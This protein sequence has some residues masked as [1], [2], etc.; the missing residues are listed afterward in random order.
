MKSFKG[1]LKEEVAWQQSTSKMIFDFGDKFSIKIP[2]S[3]AILDKIFPDKIKTTVFH[4]TDVTKVEKLI[5]LQKKQKMVSSFF[6]MDTNYLTMGINTGGGVVAELDGN[7]VV[8]AKSDI[9]SMPDK[10]G[11]RWIELGTLAEFGAI[12]DDAV[13]M[14]YKLGDKYN[15][16]K[17]VE[18]S[19]ILSKAGELFKK[20]DLDLAPIANFGKYWE[21][22]GLLD[23]KSKSLLIKDY[24]DG[25]TKVLKKNKKT[26]GAALRDYSNK[27]I[28]KRSWDEQLVN[29]F[30]IEKIHLLKTQGGVS[31]VEMFIHIY[32]ILKKSRIPVKDWK[33]D[34]PGLATYIK[35]VGKAEMRTMGTK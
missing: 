6:F 10:T 27:R 31:T 5:R 14:I 13:D 1:Y 16:H 4:L 2:V 20:L 35:Q 12:E 24:I 3:S 32:D 8:S 15:W 9:M 22:K 30:T 34:S 17:D 21:L 29:Q 7:V 23:N 11:R 19:A 18:D 25:M 33:N 28:T 26:V